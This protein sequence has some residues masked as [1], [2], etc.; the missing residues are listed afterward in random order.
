M[1]HQVD[2]ILRSDSLL[3]LGKFAWQKFRSRH[4]RRDWGLILGIAIWW[5]VNVVSFHPLSKQMKTDSNLH[6][7]CSSVNRCRGLDL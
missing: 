6:L 1:C 4:R 3:V 7:G 2:K 5:L